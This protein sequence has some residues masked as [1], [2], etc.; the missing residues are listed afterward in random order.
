MSLESGNFQ[1]VY[2]E[3]ELCHRLLIIINSW[4][5]FPQGRGD[6]FVPDLDRAFGFIRS[7]LN[8]TGV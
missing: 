2:V 1:Y 8:D 4:R 5:F 3:T 7:S 6:L